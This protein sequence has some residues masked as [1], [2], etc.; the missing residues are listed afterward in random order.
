MIPEAAEFTVGDD[1]WYSFS[2]DHYIDGAVMMDGELRVRNEVAEDYTQLEIENHLIWYTHYKDVP[3]I[4]PGEA[5]Q[6]L[7]DGSFAYA[8]ALMHYAKDSVNVLSCTLDYEIDTKGFYQPVYI[9]EIMYPD[10]GNIDTII[11]PAMK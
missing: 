1:G 5:Y 10:T 2:C 6:V 7:K 11:I 8:E 9:F 4:T 3:V